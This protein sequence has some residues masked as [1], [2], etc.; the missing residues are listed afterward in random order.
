MIQNTGY[1]I[2]VSTPPP[3]NLKFCQG[4]SNTHEPLITSGDSNASIYPLRKGIVKPDPALLSNRMQSLKKAYSGHLPESAAAY[5]LSSSISTA[6]MTSVITALNQLKDGSSPLISQENQTEVLIRGEVWK[7]KMALLN[8]AISQLELN[9]KSVEINLEYY[10]FSNPEMI[11]KVRHALAL[12]AKV[13]ILMDPGK[14]DAQNDSLD[15]SSLA[16]RLQTVS[17]LKEGMENQDLAIAFFP[18]REQLT[19]DGIMHRKIFRV[20]NTVI[21]T[22]MNAGFGSGEDVDCGFALRGA[23]ADRL[24]Q[25][26]KDDMNL[27]HHKTESEIYGN[28]IETLIN[29]PSIVLNREGTLRFFQ[30]LLKIQT[31][32]EKT[33]KEQAQEVLSEASKQGMKVQKLIQ[34][35]PEQML[36][37]SPESSPALLTT[38]GKELLAKKMRTVEML[39]VSEKNQNK[40]L[41]AN[42]SAESSGNEAVITAATPIERQALILFGIESAERF[43]KIPAFVLTKGIAN[44]LIA[45]KNEMEKQGK[46]FSIQ[47]ILDPGLYNE[48]GKYPFNPNEPSFLFLQEHN[49]PVKWAAL[50]R[51]TN[52]HDRKLHSK[53]IITDQLAITGSTNFSDKGLRKNWEISGALLF[54]SENKGKRAKL[55]KD[56]RT[57][58]ENE[59]LAPDIKAMAEKRFINR[60]DVGS[61]EQMQTY[62]FMTTRHFLRDLAEL[63]KETGSWMDAY[64]QDSF[65]KHEIA[66]LIKQGEHPGIAAFKVVGDQTMKQI[67]DKTPIWRKMQSYWIFKD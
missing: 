2:P 21:L 32:S 48:T 19:K 33:W 1:S 27:A 9:G 20:G 14:L 22:G 40:M 44:A 34:L 7:K 24:I 17:L 18:N 59:S 5:F 63:E 60:Q 56:F 8:H 47:V 28:Q 55:E 3:Q 46:E 13:R 58:Y 57:L 35:S 12:G 6:D 64:Q 11:Q 15:A 41:D 36:A 16:A 30:T 31:A 38:E 62:N 49:I 10:E 51:S 39:L 50:E 29:H 43:I 54:N 67:R 4:S 65:N 53:T 37:S 61:P 42:L 52:D 26:F 23:G 66:K 45:K 25:I